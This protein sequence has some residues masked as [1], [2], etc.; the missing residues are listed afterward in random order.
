MKKRIWERR[1]KRRTNMRET[2]KG[3]IKRQFQKDDPRK[4]KNLAEELERR[5]CEEKGRR[6]AQWQRRK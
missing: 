6:V 3:K 4:E 5:T 1:V 2:E